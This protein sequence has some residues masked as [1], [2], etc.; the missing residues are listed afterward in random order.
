M[1][2][3]IFGK[4]MITQEEMRKRI[5][6]LGLRIAQDYQEKDLLMIGV[7]K[8]A[9]VF[10]SDLARAVP[11]PLHVDFLVVSSYGEK[12]K[13]SGAVK[14]ISDTTQNL[15]GKDVLVVE[16]IV[17]SGLTLTFLKKKLMA[18]KPNSLRFCTLLDKPQRRK[19][20]VTIDYVGFTIPNKYVVG[21]GLD[22][23]NKYRNLPYI[24]V[25]EN[26]QEDA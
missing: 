18:R 3:R 21:Y 24:A 2:G 26:V 7:L 11:L 6:E 9:F 5:Q 10:F 4:P 15:K 17:D 23:E 20:E 1:E 16:D 22:Y 8:G 19:T 14:V 13:S 12:K 25:L